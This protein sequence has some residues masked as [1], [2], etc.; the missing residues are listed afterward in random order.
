[1]IEIS[2]EALITLLLLSLFTGALVPVIIVVTIKL[3][4]ISK[5]LKD[6]ANKTGGNR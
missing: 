3:R 5:R 1:M 2:K 4:G 6:L